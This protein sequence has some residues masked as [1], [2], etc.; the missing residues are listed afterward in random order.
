MTCGVC[1]S[2]RVLRSRVFT[3]KE[4]VSASFIVA[5]TGTPRTAAPCTAASS[6]TF[7]TSSK[8]TKGLTE[9]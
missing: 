2:Q 5:F 9:S 4:S 7:L 6:K 3:T 1:I 8:E